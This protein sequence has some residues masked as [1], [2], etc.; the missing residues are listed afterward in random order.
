LHV[1][2]PPGHAIKG[3]YEAIVFPMRYDATLATK[4]DHREEAGQLL[5]EER[6]DEEGVRELEIT[7][8]PAGARAQLQQDPVPPGGQ[9]IKDEY[10]SHRW[11]VLPGCLQSYLDGTRHDS[12]GIVVGVY[13][14]MTFK[15]KVTSDFVVFQA[16]ARYLGEYFLLDQV[17]GQWGFRECKQQ[18]KDFM[19]AHPK[20]TYVKLEDAANAAAMVDDLARVI[21][22]LQLAPVAGG[23]LA[24][25]Q[26]VEGVWASGAVKL[27]A[28]APWLGGSD[29]FVAEHLA[30]DGLGTRHDDQVATGNLALLDLSSGSAA[31]YVKAWQAVLEAR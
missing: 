15:G 18:L 2:D 30:Y 25:Q 22:G 27:P 17:R 29:G 8:G 3:G 1:D 13:G 26:Q 7:L 19:A 11:G 6:C 14:D 9:L 4:Q 24:R 20:A 12:T 10:L 21:R 31:S 23:C 16:W 5:C 28:Q